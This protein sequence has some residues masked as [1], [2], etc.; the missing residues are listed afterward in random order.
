MRRAKLATIGI[1]WVVCMTTALGL[2]TLLSP[3]C[4]QNQEQPSLQTT[5]QDQRPAAPNREYQK[6]G[7]VI[8]V[9]NAT[10]ATSQ[11]AEAMSGAVSKATGGLTLPNGIEIPAGGVTYVQIVTISTGDQVPSQ[12]GSST[13]AG[14]LTQTPSMNPT[15]SG[16][17]EPRASVQ[18][19]IPIAVMPGSY[20]SAQGGSATGEGGTSGDQTQTSTADLKTALIKAAGDPAKRADLL[21]FIEGLFGIVPI[22]ATQPAEKAEP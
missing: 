5:T 10:G 1:C 8:N 7:H 11:P 21:G 14:T 18:A 12:T 15:L 2:L 17:Q 22:P 3:G 9:T 20:A 6:T 19:N 4:A 16:N 13:A